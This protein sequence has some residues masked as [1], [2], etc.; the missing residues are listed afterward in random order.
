M[1]TFEREKQKETTL[2]CCSVN[3]KWLNAACPVQ[4]TRNQSGD[5]LR[6]KSEWHC[7]NDFIWM[8]PRR[9]S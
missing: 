3:S 6:R 2:L 5:A 9:T 8:S 1:M 4:A 7:P